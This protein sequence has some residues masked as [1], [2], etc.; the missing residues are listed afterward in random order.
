[1]SI[2]EWAFSH[3]A[4]KALEHAFESSVAYWSP[5]DVT[6]NWV[7]RLNAHF[8][9]HVRVLGQSK[10]EPDI[11][12]ER[13]FKLDAEQKRLAKEEQQRLKRENR[14][15]DPHAVLVT[16]PQWDADPIQF[17]A[18][19]IDYA[20]VCA[21]RRQGAKP[22]V[23][24]ANAL[25][26]CR[27]SRQLLLHERGPTVRT[28]PSCIHTLGGAYVPPGPRSVDP[29]RRGLRSTLER[30]VHEEA[31]LA[32]SGSEFPPMM[33]AKELDTGFVQLAFL[34]FAAKAS[35]LSRLEGNWEGNPLLIS[36]D[37]IPGLLLHAPNWV[38]TG[39]AHVLAWLALGA[40]NAGPKPRFGSLTAAQ[41]F[42]LVE[43]GAGPDA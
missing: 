27:E 36:F 29:D 5:R 8:A 20:G 10:R 41:L 13:N 2:P 31:Q 9:G 21:L 42:D 7:P 3:L 26:V 30:E 17:V 23:L 15:N 12:V 1:M 35:A 38:P 6:P 14:P 19:H 43:A 39:K 4:W 28:F 25:I 34:G 11:R 40:P 24:S 16:E 37:A 33:V 18:Q 22:Q 32:L